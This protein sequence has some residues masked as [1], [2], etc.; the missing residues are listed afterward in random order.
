MSIVMFSTYVLVSDRV[1]VRT[2]SITA[3][4][5]TALG[6]SMGTATFGVLR[7]DLQAP[8]GHALAALLANGLATATAFTLFFVVLDRIGATRTAIV[9]ALEAVTGIVLAAVFLGESVRPVVALGGVGVL[10]GAVIAALSTPASAEAL[11][12]ASPP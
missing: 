3:A 10:A 5:W 7:G 9:M 8:S 11:E 2:D 12:S 1:L 4:T 6:A